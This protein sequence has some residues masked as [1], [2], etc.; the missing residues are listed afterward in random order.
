MDFT[1]QNYFRD[2][3]WKII[4]VVRFWKNFQRP[5]TCPKINTHKKVVVHFFIP[6]VL[7]PKTPL[8]TYLKTKKFKGP[9]M[10]SLFHFSLFTFHFHHHDQ[11]G[12]RSIAGKNQHSSPISIK[13]S[14]H[15]IKKS[16]YNLK[17]EISFHFT[18]EILWKIFRLQIY[19]RKPLKFK[20]W[21]RLQFYK[22]NPLKNFRPSIL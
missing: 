11:K 19:K 4:R 1:S 12:K 7:L 14:P 3:F 9:K 17:T 22:K 16:L 5:P 18:R 10:D 15:F 6:M 20:N 2:H 21:N 8:L 13:E